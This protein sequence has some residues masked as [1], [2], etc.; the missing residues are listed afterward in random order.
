MNSYEELIKQC[1]ALIAYGIELQKKLDELE[2][3]IL[4]SKE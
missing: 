3:I 4:A 2:K 1:D